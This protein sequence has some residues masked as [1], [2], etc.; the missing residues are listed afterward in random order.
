MPDEDVNAFAAAISATGAVPNGLQ[1]FSLGSRDALRARLVT[2]FCESVASPR[3]DDTCGP[4]GDE[5]HSLLSNHDLLSIT[6]AICRE[7]DG[8]GCLRRDGTIYAAPMH[9]ARTKV[10][11][12]SLAFSLL[13]SWRTLLKRAES[14]VS[15]AGLTRVGARLRM[16]EAGP[17]L[18]G[19]SGQPARAD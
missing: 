19:P 11:V 4:R 1:L 9:A 2:A 17:R 16:L 5:A 15:L 10:L 3:H 13:F 14:Y 18:L 8:R 12:F 6:S 7:V